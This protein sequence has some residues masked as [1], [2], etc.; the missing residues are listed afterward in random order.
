MIA[1][2]PMTISIL[3]FVSSINAQ[4]LVDPTR[5]KTQSAIAQ[6]ENGLGADGFP[7]VNLSAIF[8]N[9]NNKHAVMNGQSIAEGE[10]WKGFRVAQVHH[11]GV[12]L[13]N[14]EKKK[15]EFLINNNNV[16]KDASDDF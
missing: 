15:K 16:K 7:K 2:Y 12:I 14:K 4:Q 6:S 3:M 11:D 10:Q 1:R 8:I 5:P 13:M 9:E